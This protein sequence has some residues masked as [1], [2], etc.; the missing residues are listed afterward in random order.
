MEIGTDTQILAQYTHNPDETIDEKFYYVHDRLGSVRL[1][2]DYHKGT[3]DTVTAVNIYTYNPFGDH[4]TPDMTGSTYN[5]FQ[6]TGQWYDAEIAQYHLR[7]RMY[8]PT[9]MRFT[10]RDPVRGEQ[11][12]PLTLHRYLYCVNDPIDRIDPRGEI[13]AAAARLT[14]AVVTGYSFY[15]H[16][17]SL[18]A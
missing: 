7:A 18:A 15:G 17:I 13:S 14:N 11:L 2:V 1:V 4:Y 9:M 12:E 10:T 8:D 5:P 6:F 16:G 3:D